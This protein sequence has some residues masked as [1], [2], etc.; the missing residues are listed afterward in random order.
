MGTRVKGLTAV[1]RVMLLTN[2]ARTRRPAGFRGGAAAA[3][4]GLFG[5]GGR[6][7]FSK[8]D[9]QSKPLE[10]ETRLVTAA[11]RNTPPKRVVQSPAGPRSA[12]PHPPA[13]RPP[14]PRHAV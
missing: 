13:P 10:A 4:K 7:S 11:R 1:C 8:D 6:M 9:G 2:P 14:P 12:R 5:G 3:A